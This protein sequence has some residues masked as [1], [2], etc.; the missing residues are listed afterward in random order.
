MF[1]VWL[2]MDSP[3]DKCFG[4]SSR[5][6]KIFSGVT[7]GFLRGTVREPIHDELRL[8]AF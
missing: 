7:M 4:G 2:R 3:H 5:C 8:V 1:G 6:A